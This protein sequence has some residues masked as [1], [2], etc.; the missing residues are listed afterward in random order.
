LQA[1]V[2]LHVTPQA[3]QLLESMVVSTHWAGAASYL[4]SVGK[5]CSHMHVP[6]S[7]LKAFSAQA[8]DPPVDPELPSAGNGLSASGTVDER[9][10]L[11]QQIPV[12]PG[13]QRDAAMPDEQFIPCVGPT[14]ELT[15]ALH[16]PLKR[17]SSSRTRSFGTSVMRFCRTSRVTPARR[18]LAVM[19]TVSV[20]SPLGAMPMLVGKNVAGFVMG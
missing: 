7:S 12:S 10:T 16:L 8:P 6:P 5:L 13:A 14:T 20:G 2:G 17:I 11:E 18:T 3:P 19:D 1:A 9:T 4:Q 15:C